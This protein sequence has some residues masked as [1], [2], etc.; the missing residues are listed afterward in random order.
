MKT[1]GTRSRRNSAVNLGDH[2]GC[3]RLVAFSDYRAQD[4]EILIREL[5]K[6]QPQPDLILYA[7]D[8]IA[9][10]RPPGGN[11]FETIASHARY[12]LCAVAGNDDLPSASG[13]ISGK[14]VFNVH[15]NPVMLGEYAILGV[16]GAPLRSDRES[17]GFLLYSENEIKRHLG[18]QAQMVGSRRLLILSHAPPD[19]VL[20]SAVRFSANHKPRSIGSRA[21]KS[22]V[23]GHKSVALLVCGHVH[24]CG[25]KHA[26]FSNAVVVNA[27]NHD[28]FEAIARLA[29]IEIEPAKRPTVQW[30][31]LRPVSM[32]PGI[33]PVAAERLAEIGVRTVE[34]LS[35]C[36]IGDLRGV[37]PSPELISARA[38]AIAQNTPILL[39]L[40]YEEPNGIEVFLDIET[41]FR[42]TYIWL[43][44]LCV[45]R[46][47]Q[48]RRFFAQSPKRE[49]RILAELL[50][51]MEAYPNARIVTCSGS[52]FEER[53]TRM[54]L[55]AHD[56]PTAICDVMDDMH[57]TIRRSVA[58]P[59]SSYRVK[60]VGS[61]F[62]YQYKHPELDGL[63]VASLYEER[64]RKLRDPWKRRTLAK[65][66]I[67][68]NEDDVRCLPFILQA[69]ERMAIKTSGH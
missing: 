57:P 37:V 45:G 21:V 54:R 40:P 56:L 34:E 52:R 27:A 26:E 36:P 53:I 51:F 64:Y 62:G 11:L 66:L 29:L 35:T 8:D 58:L 43:I 19:G 47:G 61:F 2:S 24:R 1:R 44:G 17:I 12:G 39:G 31:T 13:L 65:K 67:E 48:Y 5:S 7:G 10:F 55:A 33:G 68:Y 4:V 41:D 9:R 30:R 59:T 6:I 16:E 60:E 22:F 46:A 18:L 3:L 15:S 42:Q 63:A 20:D 50:T 49:G 32:V 25:G 28:D 14:S 69:M 38:R 23:K